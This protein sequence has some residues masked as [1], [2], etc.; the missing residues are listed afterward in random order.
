MSQLQHQQSILYIEK[1]EW[2]F[3]DMDFTVAVCSYN[4]V[5]AYMEG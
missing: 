2:S 1:V 5:M 4:K 3:A